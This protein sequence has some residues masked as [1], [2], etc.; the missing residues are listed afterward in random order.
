MTVDLGT[1]EALLRTAEV[2]MTRPDSVWGGVWP[3]AAALLTRQA[4][5]DGVDRV[6]V[7]RLAN[8][9]AA[10]MKAQMI[11]LLEYLGDRAVARRVY[12]TW[13]ALSNACHAHPFDLAPTAEELRGWGEVVGKLLV[14]T[15]P[16]ADDA[17]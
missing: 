5:E 2:V 16:L 14:A 10:S 11:C 1:P 7:G 12:A 17:A 8:M 9:R 15:A 13:Y 3:R 6:W 4:R